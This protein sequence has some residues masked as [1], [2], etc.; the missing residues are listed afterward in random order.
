MLSVS[1][2]C[3]V[4]LSVVTAAGAQPHR[5]GPEPRVGDSDGAIAYRSWQIYTTN[6]GLP[7]NRIRAI[8][9]DE[10]RVWVGTDGGL[11]LREQGR[12]RS[13]TVQDGLSA[14]VISAI[15][16]D[17]ATGEIWLGTWGSGLLRFSGGR[18]DRFDQMNSGLSG[19][20]IHAVAVFGGRVWV[21]TNSGL[22]A[23]D[24]ATGVWDLH[25]PRR[26][27]APETV[28]TSLRAANSNLYAAAWLDR[29]L[30]FDGGTADPPGGRGVWTTLHCDSTSSP[31]TEGALLEMAVA[32]R[33]IWWATVDALCHFSDTGTSFTTSANGRWG[34]GNLVR[35]MAVSDDDR[36]FVGTDRGL[37]VLIDAAADKWQVY[38][39]RGRGGVLP[40]DRIRCLAIDGGEIWVG[41]AAGL[42]HGTVGGSDRILP[43]DKSQPVPTG[44]VDPLPTGEPVR[45][46]LLGPANRTIPLP[47]DDRAGARR[48]DRPDLL[49]IQV[50][51]EQ[52]NAAGGYRG[53]ARFAL[54]DIP[55]TYIFSNY[56]WGTPEDEM[57]MLA[58]QLAIR[59]I[60]VQLRAGTRS[61]SLA[62]L[63]TELPAV[64]IASA[65]G[66]TNVTVNPWVFQFASEPRTG[67]PRHEIAL[68]HV[69]ATM[70]LTR[71][72]VIRTPGRFAKKRLDAWI[73]CARRH[74]HPPVVEVEHAD[75]PAVLLDTLRRSRVEVVLMWCDAATSAAFV[76]QMRTE[77]MNQVFVGGDALLRDEFLELVGGSAGAVIAAAVGRSPGWHPRAEEVSAFVDFY[78]S[79]N[80]IGR[81]NRGPSQHAVRSYNATRLLLEAINTAGLDRHAIRRALERLS[82]PAFAKLENG[83]WVYYTAN[84]P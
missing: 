22:S 47:G 2:M 16:I 69:F 17:G 49:A 81:S 24:G 9:V 31:A 43:S 77:G 40:D 62:I 45:I 32:D 66:G 65:R 19:N 50:A 41:T 54:A 7:H 3:G 8:K 67:G 55:D 68:E 5:V 74:G 14:P 38:R 23:F 52:A 27:D 71:V 72:A 44:R 64:H 6:D 84:D 1:G 61:T 11:A 80:Q 57:L 46:A 36:L 21:A 28:V 56:G 82:A 70:G 53:V 63:E 4:L 30:R 60:I 25:L 48:P 78:T 79:R 83:K 26:A 35:C 18:F 12:W 37:H 75:D 59:A 15:D 42:A 33:S 39:G 13:W 29:V 76:R 20:L 51:V 73:E 58:N 34:P 10:G